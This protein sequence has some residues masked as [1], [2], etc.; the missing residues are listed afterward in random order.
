MATKKPVITAAMMPFLMSIVKAKVA[1]LQAAKA[2]G[3]TGTAG[4]RQDAP[5]PADNSAALLSLV[6]FNGVKFL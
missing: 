2:A 4:I 6:S 3:S 5:P 1:A